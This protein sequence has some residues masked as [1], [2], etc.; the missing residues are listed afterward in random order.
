M[1]YFSGVI[2]LAW[3]LLWIIFVTD[4]P[5]DNCF[6]GEEEKNHILS[7]RHKFVP[8]SSFI[9]P[10]HKILKIPTVWVTALSDFAF[11]IGFYLI[12]IEGPTFMAKVLHKDITEVGTTTFPSHPLNYSLIII[13]S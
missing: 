4:D 8:N 10:L 7:S 9:P 12:I 6:I 5:E 2:G 13:S 11:G 3:H 1:F